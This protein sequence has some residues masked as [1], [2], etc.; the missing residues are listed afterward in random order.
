MFFYI[1][2]SDDT[3]HRQEGGHHI[4]QERDAIESNMIVD[5]PGFYPGDIKPKL[6]IVS[7]VIEVGPQGQR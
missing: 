7:G 4:K 3:D 6:H 1:P 5:T 2:R